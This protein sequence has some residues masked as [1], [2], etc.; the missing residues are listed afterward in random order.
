M[1]QHR[2]VVQLLAVEVRN[3]TRLCIRIERSIE[4]SEGIE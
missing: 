3:E 4:P 1:K 2:H